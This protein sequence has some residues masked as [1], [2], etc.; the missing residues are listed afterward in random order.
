MI[1][2]CAVNSSLC[3]YTLVAYQLAAGGTVEAHTAVRMDLTDNGLWF[4]LNV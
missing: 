4:W 3:C 2:G 1:I